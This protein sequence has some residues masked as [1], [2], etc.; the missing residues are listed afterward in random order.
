MTNI[1]NIEKI[2]T[3]FNYVFW[4]LTLNILFLVVNTPLILFF[5]F[6]GISSMTTYLPLFLF[7][8]IPFAASFTTLLYCMHKLIKTREVEPLKDF[9]TSFKSNFKNSTIIWICEL[10]IIFILSTNIKFFAAVGGN[11]L[12]NGFFTLVLFI[13]LLV[14]P[15]IFTLTSK[16]SMNIISTVKSAVILTITRPII[17]I[18]NILCLV[19]TLML[20]ELNPATTVLFIGSIAAFLIAFANKT[21]VKELQEKSNS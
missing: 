16:F 6:V 4:F 17:T 21:L 5:L 14:T 1:I 18:A 13:L 7:A 19:V 10:L 8:A 2:L 3:F 9:F 11:I 15:H 20:F 12:I